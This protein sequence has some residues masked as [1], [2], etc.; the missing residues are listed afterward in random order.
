MILLY[1]RATTRNRTRGDKRKRNGRDVYSAVSQELKSGK[2]T[3]F[4]WCLEAGERRFRQSNK[5]ERIASG[6]ETII[7]QPPLHPIQTPDGL[8]N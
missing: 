1:R 8:S 4:C 5:S 2:G 3:R 7:A 6:E